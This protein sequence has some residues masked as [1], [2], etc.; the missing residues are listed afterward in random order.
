MTA[1]SHLP[2]SGSPASCSPSALRGAS[3][4]ILKVTASWCGPC[5][6]IH[7]EFVKLCRKNKD[8]FHSYVL[9]IEAANSEDGDAKLLL[10]VLDVSSLPTFI[11]FR[12]GREIDRCVGGNMANV[13]ALCDIVFNTPATPETCGDGK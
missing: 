13:E 8:N 2:P 6:R 10:D 4:A 12:E 3:A 7:P 11:L 1:L 9:D 5:Q